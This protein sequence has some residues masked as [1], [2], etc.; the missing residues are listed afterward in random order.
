MIEKST[1]RYKKRHED[2]KGRKRE[3]MGTEML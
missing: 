2:N 3:G 1:D